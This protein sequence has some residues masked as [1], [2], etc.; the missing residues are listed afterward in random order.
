MSEKH[1]NQKPVRDAEFITPPNIIKAKV[2]NGGLSEA[3]ISR[4]Q[5]VLEMHAED[6]KP[7]AEIYLEQMRNGISNAKDIEGGTDKE[8]HIAQILFPC[9]QLKANGAMFKYSLI[10]QIADLF[11]QFMEVVERLD[12]ETLEIADAFYTT[13]RIVVNGKITGDGGDQGKKLTEELNNACKRYFEK[14]KETINFKK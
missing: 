13:I 2:G 6:F 10:T 8:E 5:A 14:H 4:A 12:S 3:I 9:V 7:L 1:F 11:V